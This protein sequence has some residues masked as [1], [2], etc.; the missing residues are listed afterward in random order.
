MYAHYN[1]FNQFPIT[2]CL[3]YVYI[4]KQHIPTHINVTN[5]T[6]GRIIV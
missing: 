3:A 5:N 6:S 4:Y 2:G 1:L